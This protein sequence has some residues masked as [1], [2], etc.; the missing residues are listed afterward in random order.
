MIEG[1]RRFADPCTYPQLHGRNA[2]FARARREK[3]ARTGRGKREDFRK[4]RRT[5][6]KRRGTA[7]MDGRCAQ[8]S[9]R[10]S[11]RRER[12]R[13]E[14]RRTRGGWA[15]VVGR[16]EGE[17]QREG[18]DLREGRHGEAPFYFLAVGVLLFATMTL[19]ENSRMRDIDLLVRSCRREAGRQPRPA[20]GPPFISGAVR[21]HTRGRWRVRGTRQ[22][23][24]LAVRAP[25]ERDLRR[26]GW[27]G[28]RVVTQS[29]LRVSRLFRV[30]DSVLPS[31]SSSLLPLPPSSAILEE[32]SSLLGKSRRGLSAGIVSLERKRRTEIRREAPLD[33]GRF[34]CTT[35]AAHTHTHRATQTRIHRQ[36]RRFGRGPG[37]AG[38]MI[39][40]DSLP[41][42]SLVARTPSTPTIPAQR[43]RETHPL[44]PLDGNR[45]TPFAVEQRNSETDVGAICS[46][47]SAIRVNQKK[48]SSMLTRRGNRLSRGG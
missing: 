44:A 19:R 38:T 14:E 22:G 37:I 26:R 25:R 31:S 1:E 36:S 33:S 34:C 39:R 29:S 43:S 13:E 8:G 42:V 32:R 48:I 12:E 24:R 47:T 17:E 11:L 4:R 40:R 35:H 5:E 15:E 3:H 2:S 16:L 27:G 41:R 9:H 23:R 46:S 20:I 10:E 6:E 7:S 21:I 18:D 45:S 30:R 28:G